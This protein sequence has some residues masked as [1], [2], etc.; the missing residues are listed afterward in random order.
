LELQEIYCAKGYLK[1]DVKSS[2]FE[3][4]LLINLQRNNYE[5]ANLNF[6]Y[7]CKKC[8]K[9]SPIFDKRCI[10]CNSIL[11]LKPTMKISKQLNQEIA[12]LV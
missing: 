10:N 9:V 1:R 4:D 8:K 6:N 11:S 5:K 7:S 2:K 12:S 3:L